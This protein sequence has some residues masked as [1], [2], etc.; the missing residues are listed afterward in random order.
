MQL[1][2]NHTQIKSNIIHPIFS[3]NYIFPFSATHCTNTTACRSL[4][5]AIVPVQQAAAVCSK[6]L[7]LYNRLP[8]VAG[9]CCTYS[10]ARRSLRQAIVPVQ[11]V[12]DYFLLVVQ[13][14]WREVFIATDAFF[15]KINIISFT[16]A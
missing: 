8:Q 14:Q 2:Q 16:V 5:E 12:A 4:H 11:K 9:S 1:S 15:L 7:Y 6:Q 3:K 13:V 10:T